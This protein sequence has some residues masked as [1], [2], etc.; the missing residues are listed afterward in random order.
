MQTPKTYL[1]SRIKNKEEPQLLTS[2]NP[3][4]AIKQNKTT[5]LRQSAFFS[6]I[7]D[8][9]YSFIFQP[10]T[11]TRLASIPKGGWAHL[12]KVQ[13][14][15]IF[16]D[17]T[18]NKK[19]QLIHRTLCTTFLLSSSTCHWLLPVEFVVSSK[20]KRSGAGDSLISCQKGYIPRLISLLYYI[21]LR[22][23][24]QRRHH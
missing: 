7:I 16:L 20:A 15:S 4:K 8:Q 9:G 1:L 14:Q 22:I 3:E 2:L 19:V 23:H 18:P 21:S 12:V 13:V 11:P 6:V 10:F 5:W 17:S 24:I